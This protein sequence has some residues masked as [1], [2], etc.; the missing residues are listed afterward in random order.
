M[1]LFHLEYLIPISLLFLRIIVA[2][3]FFSSGRNHLADPIKRSESLDLSPDMTRIIGILEIIAAISIAIGIVPQIGAMIIIVIML[4]AIKKKIIDWN[5]GFY[6][7]KS[8]GWHYDAI[9]LVAALL[10]MATNGG[11][12]I[13]Y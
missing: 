8:F 3:V 11:K 7:K 10:I 6:A 5:T 12:Y 9:F 2:I 4:G 13:L 1:Q